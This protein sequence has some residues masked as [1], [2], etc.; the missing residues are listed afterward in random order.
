MPSGE[1]RKHI[2]KVAKWRVDIP[3]ALAFRFENLP[4]NYDRYYCRPVFGRRSQVLTE[5]IELYVKTEEE[6]LLLLQKEKAA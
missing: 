1:R 6:K 3:Q 4:G 5:L 2:G